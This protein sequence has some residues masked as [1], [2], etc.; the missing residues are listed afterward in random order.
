MSVV[1][2]CIQASKIIEVSLICNDVEIRDTQSETV[3]IFA[4]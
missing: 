2:T 4:H 1:L 3:E